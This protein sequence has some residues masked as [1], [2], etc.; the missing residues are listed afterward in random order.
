M[1]SYTGNDRTILFF[2]CCLLFFRIEADQPVDGPY[3]YGAEHRSI[4]D[5]HAAFLIG[6]VD[7]FRLVSGSLINTDVGVEVSTGRLGR[8]G[9]SC[10]EQVFPF[11][12]EVFQCRDV[13][14]PRLRISRIHRFEFIIVE[15]FI[16]QSG[17]TV[18]EFM[19]YDRT[20]GSVA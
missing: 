10:R 8:D 11:C 17:K 12:I 2:I 15:I 7:S 5:F 13:L 3:T 4:V 16:G 1:S 20:E 6:P 14:F 9:S 19:Y 18:A